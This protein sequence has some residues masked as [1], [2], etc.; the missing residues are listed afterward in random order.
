MSGVDLLA[1]YGQAT[2]EVFRLEALAD[3]A[4]QAEPAQLREAIAVFL[5]V[6][7]NCGNGW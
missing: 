5:D 4:V 6:A 3:Y 7:G 1:L 2:R